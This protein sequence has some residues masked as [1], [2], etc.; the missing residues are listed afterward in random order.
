[1]IEEIK[2]RTIEAV[3][4]DER[5]RARMKG[6]RHHVLAAD[7][8]E[9]KPTGQDKRPRRMAEIGIY[10]YDKDVLVVAV[11][12]LQQGAVLAV[13]ERQGVQPPVTEEEIKA[14]C[15]LIDHSHSSYERLSHPGTAVVAFPAPR[16]SATHARARNRCV[17]LYSHPSPARPKTR[18]PWT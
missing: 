10:D 15:K 5:V 11:V 18:S 7:Y 13:E 12:D 17:T 16:Y 4:A 8:R 14:A 9:D 1:M 3:L 2:E 6:V